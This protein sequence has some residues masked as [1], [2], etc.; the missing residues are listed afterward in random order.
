M[1]LIKEQSA[2][3]LIGSGVGHD[4]IGDVMHDMI[5]IEINLTIYSLKIF[6]QND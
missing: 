3:P 1:L 5:G 2:L 4:V 6:K